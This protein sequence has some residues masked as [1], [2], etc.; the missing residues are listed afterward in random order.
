MP[1]LQYLVVPTDNTTNPLLYYHGNNKLQMRT[2]TIYFQHEDGSDDQQ[3]YTEEWVRDHFFPW[4]NAEIE[5]RFGS[6]SSLIFN[7]EEALQDWIT[8]H[9]AVLKDNT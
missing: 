6:D 1:E 5:K 3:D 7:F 9:D 8:V 2:Y 4:W